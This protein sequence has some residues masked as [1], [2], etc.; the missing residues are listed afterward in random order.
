MVEGDDVVRPKV[1]RRYR[2]IVVRFREER[3]A[4]LNHFDAKHPPPKKNMDG[5]ITFWP[6]SD[7]ENACRVTFIRSGTE[8][9]IVNLHSNN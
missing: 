1:R 5:R 4:T 8:V 7:I 3:A 9:G 2:L 6:R